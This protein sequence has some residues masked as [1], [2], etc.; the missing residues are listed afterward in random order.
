MS[1]FD[2]VRIQVHLGIGQDG[3]GN[4][5][6]IDAATSTQRQ[7]H[8]QEVLDNVRYCNKEGTTID[9]LE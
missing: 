4:T 6:S 7:I 8:V 9:K 5:A 2:V 3:S 1:S